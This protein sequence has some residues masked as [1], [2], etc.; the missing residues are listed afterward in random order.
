M[1][2]GLL[3]ISRK[4][5]DLLLGFLQS[6]FIREIRGSL[7]FFSK[8]LAQLLFSLLFVCLVFSHISSILHIA[9]EIRL[10]L[11]QDIDS[12]SECLLDSGAILHLSEQLLFAL[13]F[14]YVQSSHPDEVPYRLECLRVL[15]PLIE[16]IV[17]LL[18][19]KAQSSAP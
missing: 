3:L 10:R 12:C 11:R 17:D 16:D 14:R 5:L 8:Y 13:Y 4:G 9:S 1:S 2:C 6:L 18:L 19:R 7:Q 15:F